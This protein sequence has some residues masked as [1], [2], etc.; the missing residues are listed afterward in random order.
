MC[1]RIFIFVAPILLCFFST[2]LF[3]EPFDRNKE[4]PERKRAII[5]IKNKAASLGVN[6]EQINRIKHPSS[7]RLKTI[8]RLGGNQSVYIQ[9]SLTQEEIKSIS[10]TNEV[11]EVFDNKILTP[12]LSATNEMIGANI[13]A[14]HQYQ[15]AATTIAVLDTG[16]DL[17]HPFIADAIVAEACFSTNDDNYYSFCPNEADASEQLGSATHCTS[18]FDCGHGTHVAGIIAGRKNIYPNIQGVASEANLFPIQVYSGCRTGNCIGAFTSD[19]M[20]ALQLVLDKREQ[21]NIVAVNMSLNDKS[22]Y[23]GYCHSPL[24][25]LIRELRL[26]GVAVVISAGNDGLKDKTAFPACT[27]GAIA[28]TATDANHHLLPRS[29]ISPIVKVAAPGLGI[30]SSILNHNFGTMTGTSMAA[31]QV[32]AM[33][34]IYQ[35]MLPGTAVSSIEDALSPRSLSQPSTGMDFHPINIFTTLSRLPSLPLSAHSPVITNLSKLSDYKCAW[36]EIYVGHFYNNWVKDQLLICPGGHEVI[37]EEIRLG[38]D[39]VFISLTDHYFLQKN[40][41]GDIELIWDKN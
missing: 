11:V 8:K 23:E 20:Q 16:V 22:F 6:A 9:G 39:S 14:E 21:L 24:E 5:H 26:R 19:L 3:A 38:T 31:P 33:I 36:K 30:F 37:V 27:P 10:E 28:V 35:S 7:A 13:M 40:A 29:N 34:A 2:N 18:H 1:N 41:V 12:Q 25:P 4:Q 17:H 32:A 15:G